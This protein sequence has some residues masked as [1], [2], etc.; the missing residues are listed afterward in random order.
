M[1]AFTEVEQFDLKPKCNA[2]LTGT[3][4]A[5][6]PLAD[7]WKNP[8]VAGSVLAAV[9]QR[10]TRGLKYS[11]SRAVIQILIVQSKLLFSKL[12]L[13]FIVGNQ[14]IKS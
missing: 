14:Q 3:L 9:G 10:G 11:I 4:G 8:L 7:G 13:S 2:K 6:R 1:E 12:K 5:V